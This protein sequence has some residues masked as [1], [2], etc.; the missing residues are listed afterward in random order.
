MNIINLAS[1]NL[2]F[3]LRSCTPPSTNPLIRCTRD[4]VYQSR[5]KIQ[6][7][8]KIFKNSPKYKVL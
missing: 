6:K 3:A 4:I 5:S 7:E 1:Y 2:P 8:S